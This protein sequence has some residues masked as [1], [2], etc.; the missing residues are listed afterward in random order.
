MGVNNPWGG[1]VFS[2]RNLREAMGVFPRPVGCAQHPHCPGPRFQPLASAIP[3]P[4]VRSTDHPSGL[5]W[6]K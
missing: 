6:P 3:A 2:G 5:M 4:G 1:S